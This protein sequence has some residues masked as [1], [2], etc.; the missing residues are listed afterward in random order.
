MPRAPKSALLGLTSLLALLLV[1]CSADSEPAK[2]QS[3]PHGVLNPLPAGSYLYLAG[4]HRLTIVDVDAGVRWRVS[5]PSAATFAPRPILLR[6][7]DR[8]VYYARGGRIESIDLNLLQGP[9]RLATTG[10]QAPGYFIPSVRRD[11]IWVTS[12]PDANGVP[13]SVR[14]ITA[15]GRPTFPETPLPRLSVPPYHR[16]PLVAFRSALGVGSGS[17]GA[18]AI[19]RPRA[20]AITFTLRTM[21]PSPLATRG[22]LLAVAGRKTAGDR[23]RL[24][25]VITRRERLFRPS[26]GFR[27]LDVWGGA[28]SPAGSFLAVPVTRSRLS[29][30]R[31]WANR[32]LSLIDVAAG[33]VRVVSGS[34]VRA[35]GLVT[36]GS[37][38]RSV[39]MSGRDRGG[40]GQ[41]IVYRLGEERAHRIP[42]RIGPVYGMAAS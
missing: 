16:A 3:G 1:A 20:N 10:P 37:D 22:N 42:I 41:V 23:L 24:I 35:G 27:G 29:R 34:A 19:W 11:R 13:T 18:I 12:R 9:R 38:G 40:H 8:L 17:K 25:N 33:R 14:E 36:W 32:W 26:Q 7:G 21:A 2:V 30:A 4:E 15:G 6:R 31:P 39:F 28:F 5:R